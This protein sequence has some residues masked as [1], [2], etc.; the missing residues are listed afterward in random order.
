[1]VAEQ[2]AL[3]LILLCLPMAACRSFVVLIGMM[4]IAINQAG[5]VTGCD[6]LVG[7]NL[8]ALVFARGNLVPAIFVSNLLLAVLVYRIFSCMHRLSASRLATTAASCSSA[9]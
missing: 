6:I 4:C 5:L 3:H 2:H 8:G 9:A 1:V 7:R